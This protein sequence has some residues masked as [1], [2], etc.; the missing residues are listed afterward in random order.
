MNGT[1]LLFRIGI[2][3][4]LAVLTSGCTLEIIDP[5][6][7]EVIAL[8]SFHGRYVTAFGEG[9]GWKLSQTTE[10]GDCGWF[11]L[12]YLANGKVTLQT[13]HDR[14]IT[15]P[16]SGAEDI[17][18]I[19]TQETKPGRCGQFDLYEL[20]SDRIALKTC[21]NWFITAGDGNWPGVL[22]WSVVGET[23]DLMDWEKLTML[24]P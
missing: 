24:K 22:A 8:Q 21:A 1:R 2:V 5:P 10:L 3:V 16:E 9:A 6:Q 20:G 17:D 4:G 12:N 15:A 11:T 18:W 13:C 19:I 23:E 7:L 14:Y